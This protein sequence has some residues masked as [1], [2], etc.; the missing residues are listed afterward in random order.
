MFLG[1]TIRLTEKGIEIEGDDK[2]TKVLIK[3]WNLEGG[4]GVDTPW[5]DDDVCLDEEREVLSKPEAKVFRRAAARINYM[6]LERIDLGHAS[7]EISKHMAN[8]KVGDDRK[9][10]RVIR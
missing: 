9:I 4:K 8:P 1:R 5:S 2:H 7:K 6:S 3:E 10:K